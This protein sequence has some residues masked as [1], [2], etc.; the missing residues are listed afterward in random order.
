[1]PNALEVITRVISEHSKITDHTKLA[2]DTMNDID[3]FFTLETTKR[4][5]AWS[6]TSVAELIKKR[7]QLLH[8]ID[9]LEDGL[10]NHFGYEEEVL[11]LV[12]GE[13]LMK[14]ILHEHQGI[15]G[16]IDNAKTN[17]I[18]LERMS[19]D[20]LFSNRTEVLQSVNNLCQTVKDHAHH[21][22]TALNAMRKFLE[23]N[24]AYRD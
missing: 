20:E 7:D 17:L 9:L 16:Q 19:R 12:L 24:S 21:E 8:T 15:L 5:A 3:A 14:P 18:N 2:G 10:K 4:K 1:M 23:E 13:L 6:A 22:E 11:P